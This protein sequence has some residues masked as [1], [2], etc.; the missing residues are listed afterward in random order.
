V[1]DFPDRFLIGSDTWVNQRWAYYEELMTG[2]RLWLGGLPADVASNI[3]WRNG[4][5]LFGL[6]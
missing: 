2:Y 1:L 3:G 6:N 4:A 5:K